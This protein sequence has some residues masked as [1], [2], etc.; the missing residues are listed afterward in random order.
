MSKFYNFKSIISFSRQ[1]LYPIF[2]KKIPFYLNLNKKNNVV[3]YEKQIFNSIQKNS[4]EILHKIKNKLTNKQEEGINYYEFQIFKLI[5]LLIFCNFFQKKNIEEFQEEE[6]KINIGKYLKKYYDLKFDYLLKFLKEMITLIPY[7]DSIKQKIILIMRIQNIDDNFIEN[8]NGKKIEKNTSSLNKLKRNLKETNNSFNSKEEINSNNKNEIM[9]NNNDKN[10]FMNK[11]NN[12]NNIKNN[13][14]KNNNNIIHNKN[15]NNNDNNGIIH[16][17]NNNNNDNKNNRIH[18]K[19]NNN[20]DNNNINNKNHINDKV[21]NN[22]QYENYENIN[23]KNQNNNIN[24]CLINDMIE[25]KENNENIN[26]SNINQNHN[27]YITQTK[28]ENKIQTNNLLNSASSDSNSLNENTYNPEIDKKINEKNQ[29]QNN[30][31]FTNNYDNNINNNNNDNNIYSNNF[32]G[33]KK[34]VDKKI[35]NLNIQESLNALYQPNNNNIDTII[36]ENLS[37]IDESFIPHNVSDLTNPFLIDFIKLDP[38]I[39]K[40]TLKKKS[41]PLNEIEK[42]MN[43]KMN[44]YQYN[45]LTEPFQFISQNFT[46]NYNLNNNYYDNNNNNNLNGINSRLKNLPIVYNEIEENDYFENKKISKLETA[47]KMLSNKKELNKEKDNNNIYNYYNYNN[48]KNNNYYNHYNYFSNNNK[49]EVDKNALKKFIHKTF[50]PRSGLS[51]DTSIK[52]S[53]ISNS[54]LVPGT[55]NNQ[56]SFEDFDS[57]HLNSNLFHYYNQKQEH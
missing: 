5:S 51:S 15:N 27:Y 36:S 6:I 24:E 42:K 9:N 8:F 45:K 53:N 20:N 12:D 14:M 19:N 25:E 54:I 29:F 31:L 44:N 43:K 10:N 32:L 11:Y 50:Y 21:Y 34:K 22:N 17:K 1:F 38:E 46:N 52:N 3:N 33:K 7:F 48:N 18:N 23:Y 13:S 49:N 57:F 26:K 47:K 35:N 37:S 56:E 30:N 2:I 55:P 41:F 40:K 28:Y 16:N 39:D 4:E